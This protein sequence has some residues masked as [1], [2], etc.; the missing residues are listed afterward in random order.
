MRIH[1]NTFIFQLILSPVTIYIQVRLVPHVPRLFSHFPYIT[2]AGVQSRGGGYLTNFSYVLN[3]L[4]FSDLPKRC[5]PIKN[6]IPIWQV[7]LQLSCYET[8]EC[9]SNDAKD[10]L[11]SSKTI[12]KTEINQSG[13]GNPHPGELL[14]R[15][16]T[17][18][19]FFW[20]PVLVSIEN[21]KSIFFNKL[22][23]LWKLPNYFLSWNEK[24]MKNIPVMS[25]E[26]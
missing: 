12:P 14:T 9:D 17:K 24:Q 16:T 23:I 15:H 18:A 1:V 7:S 6:H 13:A 5:L 4:P 2:W 25:H 11:A 22:K 3:F 20:I 26:W 10:T 8:Y 19:N 21:H